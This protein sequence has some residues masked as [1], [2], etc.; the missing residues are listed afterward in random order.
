MIH[1]TTK[2]IFNISRSKITFNVI[3]LYELSY[4]NI[5]IS[6]LTIRTL[7][8]LRELGMRQLT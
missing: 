7:L 4:K 1:K 3:K 5:M 2:Y 8:L 6:C